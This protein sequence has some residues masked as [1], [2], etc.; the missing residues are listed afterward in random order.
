MFCI[1]EIW[2]MLWPI[3]YVIKH[4]I[5]SFNQISMLLLVD[6]PN[7][8]KWT[9]YLYVTFLIE[10]RSATW[11]LNEANFK[12]WLENRLMGHLLT[13]DSWN[14]WENISTI[15]TRSIS[16][17]NNSIIRTFRLCIC[18]HSI[19][20]PPKSHVIHCLIRWHCHTPHSCGKSFIQ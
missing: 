5:F 18:I 15:N 20:F 13:F 3:S 7:C 11:P 16:R 6:M 10:S 14:R 9:F 8:E 4:R 1:C 17:L 12:I 19:H 2:K